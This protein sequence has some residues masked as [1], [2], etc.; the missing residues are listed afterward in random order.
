ME[1]DEG[2]LWVAGTRVGD[3]VNTG[4]HPPLPTPLARTPPLVLDPVIALLSMHP[5]THTQA[6]IHKHPMEAATIGATPLPSLPGVSSQA[7]PSSHMTSPRQARS[8][9]CCLRWVPCTPPLRQLAAACGRSHAPHRDTALQKRGAQ[10]GSC[11]CLRRAAVALLKAGLCVR[12]LSPC[13]LE[14]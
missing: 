2:A 5:P 9:R 14:D 1:D 8:S 4:L 12:T 7:W 10:S 11:R 6:H 3:A 13:S